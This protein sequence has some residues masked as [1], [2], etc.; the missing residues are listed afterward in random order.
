MSDIKMPLDGGCI[1]VLL[2]LFCFA[3][4][5]LGFSI[6]YNKQLSPDAAPL[7]EDPLRP[8]SPKTLFP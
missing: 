3:F 6:F 4:A 8:G 1:S 7:N 2:L 5:F